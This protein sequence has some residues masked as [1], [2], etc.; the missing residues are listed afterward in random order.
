MTV[1]KIGKSSGPPGP[2][3]Y[4]G[5]ECPEMVSVC[6][7]A[8]DKA[9]ALA[10]QTRQILDIIEGHLLKT[11]S[12]RSRLLMVQVWLADITGFPEFRDAWNAWI[13]PDNVPA[14][15]VVQAQASRR[16]SLVEIRAYAAP[17]E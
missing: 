2:N 1:T 5:A 13:D 15:S 7:T 10:D 6:L 12:S 14:L 8:P 16:D 17:A 4:L 3:M 11:G 9:G